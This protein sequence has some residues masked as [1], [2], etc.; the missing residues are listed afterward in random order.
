MK[1]WPRYLTGC[2]LGI[3]GFTCGAQA[4]AFQADGRHVAEWATGTTGTVLL[5]TGL[6]LVLA[7]LSAQLHRWRRGL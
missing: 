7:E 3:A 4:N 2:V 5:T 6:F 1:G